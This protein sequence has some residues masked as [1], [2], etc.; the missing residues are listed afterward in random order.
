LR[1]FFCLGLLGLIGESDGDPGV[2]E[3]RTPASHNDAATPRRRSRR[4]RPTSARVSSILVVLLLLAQCPGVHAMDPDNAASMGAGLVGTVIASGVATAVFTRASPVPAMALP[5]WCPSDEEDGADDATGVLP[6]W[7]PS[8]ER[9]NTDSL[10]PVPTLSEATATTPPLAATSLPQ[11]D[12]NE[13]DRD[14]RCYADLRAVHEVLRDRSTTLTE[15]LVSPA[16]QQY[17]AVSQGQRD[18]ER[19]ALVNTPRLLDGVGKH[20]KTP[21]TATLLDGASMET[22]KRIIPTS[23]VPCMW[24]GSACVFFTFDDGNSGAVDEG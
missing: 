6:A 7:D 9:N 21:V 17:G 16:C 4:S 3:E 12:E 2:A 15:L 14:D 1:I 22:V 20:N 5:A 23:M 11:Y 8:D 24:V 18:Y 10:I 13:S 19:I